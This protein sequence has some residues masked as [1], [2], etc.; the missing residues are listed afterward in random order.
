M[1]AH[2]VYNVRIV[3]KFYLPFSFSLTLSPRVCMCMCVRNGERVLYCRE[4]R[5]TER[6]NQN[7]RS[8][9]ASYDVKYKPVKRDETSSFLADVSNCMVR[10]RSFCYFLIGL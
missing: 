3:P 1:Y 6:T 5:T 9:S 2:N 10:F 4:R 7:N 8:V